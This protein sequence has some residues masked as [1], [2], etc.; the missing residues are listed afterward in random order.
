M[1]LGPLSGLEWLVVLDGPQVGVSEDIWKLHTKPHVKKIEDIAKSHGLSTRVMVNLQAGGSAVARN[2]ALKEA[3]APLVATL[4]G[5]DVIVPD[6]L[7]ALLSALL[8]YPSAAWAAGRCPHMTREGHTFWDGPADPFNPG[9]VEIGA[10]W[11][12]KRETGNLP[13]ICNATLVW[14]Q[15][16]RR[17]GGW[18][19]RPR[20]R[21]AD[22]ALWA[23]LT[24]RFPGVWVPRTIYRYRRHD[25]SVTMQP[26]FRRQTENLDEI[27]AM[28]DAG[29]TQL[30]Q[31]PM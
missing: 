1:K 19:S 22:T 17:C 15:A 6:G 26:G 24:S 31:W 21:A 25:A 11:K 23:V 16:L 29:T 18:P 28:I 13:F 20:P 12:F 8:Q 30:P 4:D 14:T 7:E 9:I 27:A 2:V 3:Q 10:F 5:D